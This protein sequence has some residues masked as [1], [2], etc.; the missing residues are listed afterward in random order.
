MDSISRRTFLQ[1]G[2]TT[3]AATAAMRRSTAAA[4]ND[5]IVLG[6]MGVRGRG[7]ELA[8][9]F[10]K[11][12]DVRIAYIC[13]P[14]EKVWE[15]CI[16]AIGDGQGTPP[17]TVTDFREILNDKSVHGFVVATPDHWHALATIEACIA[18]KDVYVEKPVSHNVVEGRR[19]VEA[20]R[21]LDRVVQVGTQRRSSPRLAEMVEFVRSGK[22]GKVSLCRTWITSKRPSIG[23]APDEP[24][25]PGLDYDLWLGPAPK[26]AF[27]RNHFHY[28]WHWFWQYGTGELGNNGIHA[29]DLARWALDLGYPQSVVSSGGKFFFNDDQETPDT[30]LVSFEYPGLILTWEHRTWS[31]HGLEVENAK[32]GVA[33]YGDR[34]TV[35]TD[36]DNW[37]VYESSAQR[38]EKPSKLD[39]LH[40]RNWLDCIKTRERPNADIEIGHIS[41]ALCHLGNISYRVGRRLFWDAASES[42]ARP[43][44]EATPLLGREYRSPWVLPQI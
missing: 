39:G 29:L 20:A 5:T 34:G 44:P 26:R 3:A 31:P 15:P 14:D 7:K 37:R 18:G 16:A 17:K 36:G 41:T 43:D 19:M 11:E 28:H 8:R 38:P 13:D 25:P 22:L 6:I 42:F 10:S 21:K 9:I 23:F 12:P 1:V 4:Q 35:I 40:Q 30:Q 32:F 24:T 33:I 2:A 27:N